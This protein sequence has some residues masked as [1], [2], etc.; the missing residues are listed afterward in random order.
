[1]GGEGR[2]LLLH[3][4]PQRAEQI[5][6]RVRKDTPYDD[7]RRADSHRTFMA[8]LRERIDLI[9][10]A[11]TLPDG[12]AID[13]LKM[14]KEKEW[15]IP[16]IIV[17]EEGEEAIGVECLR[18]GAADY[19]SMN[20]LSQLGSSIQKT[21]D[22]AQAQR[23]K[24]H[25][26]KGRQFVQFAYDRAAVGIYWL[27]DQGRF[28]LVNE[29]A[30][31]GLG[32]TAAE[33]YQLSISD[34]DANLSPANWKKLMTQLRA[35]SAMTFESRHRHKLTGLLPVDVTANYF[36]ADDQDYILLFS[37]DITRRK[38][39]D[40]EFRR[41]E[42]QVQHAKK[43]EALG[44]LA[45]G[46]AHEFNNMLMVIENSAE[47]ILMEAKSQPQ[48]LEYAEQI[49]RTSRRAAALTSQL[50]AFSRK[51]QFEQKVL[52]LNA[53]L[54]DMFKWLR[55]L[56]RENVT[57]TCHLQPH[58]GNI[59]IDPGELGQMIINL[60]M[61]A[62]DAMPGGGDLNISTQ[63]LT[64]DAAYCKTH[65]DARPGK[66]LVVSVQDTGQGMDEETR[67]HIF[68][69]FFTT[70]ES[71]TGLGLS[72][73][74]GIVRQNGGHIECTSVK[75]KGTLFRIF[76][77]QVDLAAEPVEGPNHY[78]TLPRGRETILFVEDEPDVRTSGL[79]T[80]ERQGYK[81]LCAQNGLE[82]LALLDDYKEP[83]H[84]LI[85]DVIMPYLSGAELAKQVQKR[86]KEVRVLYTSA[87]PDGV[88]F[89]QHN[90]DLDHAYFIGKPYSIEAMAKKI[91][92]VLDA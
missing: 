36:R 3:H 18:N 4:N 19:V 68:E 70:K 66:Y 62:G 58:I 82:A 34:V 26:E 29:S 37:L 57:F 69:P 88:I 87:Y 52:D 13:V 41:M 40:E 48:S 83:I 32:Y 54:T 89:E 51:Q 35:K 39:A 86:R 7:I 25:L 55:R 60:V 73:V 10:T 46:M 59:K 72:I 21:L 14:I 45:G 16:V 8:A 64:I 56:L 75:G 84:L 42:Q 65:I 23:R 6:H 92:Q 76:L 43:M 77:P 44:R 30:A 28:L 80:L 71:G 9:L 12:S 79:R 20:Q 50:L 74:F 90:V 81:V 11:P 22:L 91:R 61:N 85:T 31:T 53:T 67:S 5:L 27:N 17:A 49:I 1:M 33:M 63:A 78:Q 38:K 2:I 47:F 24:Q 15:L